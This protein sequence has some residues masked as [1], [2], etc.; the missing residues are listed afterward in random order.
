MYLH[1]TTEGLARSD[2]TLTWGRGVDHQGFSLSFSFAIYL[3]TY[4]QD[5]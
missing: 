5:Q 4:L 2:A 3:D 1:S